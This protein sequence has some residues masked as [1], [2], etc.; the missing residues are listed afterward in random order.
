M[1]D[2]CY[3]AK[4]KRYSNYGGRGITVSDDWHDFEKFRTDMADT[5]SSGLTLER[6]EN[7]K[8][9]SKENCKWATP[10]EQQ[11]NRRNNVYVT[12]EGK[13]VL[14]CEL[15]EKYQ[16]SRITAW[17]RIFLNKW[18]VEKAIKEPIEKNDYINF[19]GQTISI[20]DF[21]NRFDIDFNNAKYRILRL[22]WPLEK[23]IFKGNKDAFR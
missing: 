10:K 17:R 11:R 18:P 21:A 9:Y 1:K 16:V 23:V 7:S 5:Y 2:R 6:L 14:L 15:C 12:F 19:E 8:G 20:R 22:K 13:L 3:N 4:H